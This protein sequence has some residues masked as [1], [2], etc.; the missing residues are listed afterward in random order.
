[1][2]LNPDQVAA[3]DLTAGDIVRAIQ[4]QNVQVSAGQI[5]GPPQPDASDFTLSINAQGRLATEEEFGNIIIKTGEGGRVTR[6]RDVARIELGASEY[7]LRSLLDKVP[8]CCF[9]LLPIRR[10]CRN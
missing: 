10:T 6:L 5:G 3:R 4:D 2:W 8:A 7:A 9:R 1:M